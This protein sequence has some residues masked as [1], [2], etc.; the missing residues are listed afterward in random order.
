MCAPLPLGH[1]PLDEVVSRYDGVLIFE[2][3]IKD[4]LLFN[5]V[6]KEHQ[7]GVDVEITSSNRSVRDRRVFTTI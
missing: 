3:S 5:N 4:V 6:N 1:L 7:F 2:V